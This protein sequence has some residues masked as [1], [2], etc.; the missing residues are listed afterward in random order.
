M[1]L[2]AH[3]KLQNLVLSIKTKNELYVRVDLIFLK[4]YFKVF[5]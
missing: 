1:S 4:F 3:L 2:D 5:F